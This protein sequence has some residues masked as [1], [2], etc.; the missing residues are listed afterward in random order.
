VVTIEDYLTLIPAIKKVFNSS[1][2]AR[3]TDTQIKKLIE[4]LLPS[5]QDLITAKIGTVSTVYTP[6]TVKAVETAVVAAVDSV[7][8]KG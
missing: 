3:P 4:G 8:E 2:I 7:L 1:G 5:I 6:D